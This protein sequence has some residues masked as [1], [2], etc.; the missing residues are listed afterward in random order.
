MPDKTPD[1]KLTTSD[2]RLSIAAGALKPAASEEL[3]RVG[4]RYGL[5]IPLT[6]T[7]STTPGTG[8]SADNMHA[9]V[10]ALQKR[11]NELTNENM[12]LKQQI[13]EISKPA[14]S[15][16]D[17]AR[18]LQHSLDT[19]QSRFSAMSNPISDFALKEFKLDSTVRIEVNKVGLIEYRFIQP[20]E[21]VR[22]QEISRIS[23]NAVP[24]PKQQTSGTMSR[25]SFTPLMGVEDID[26]VG[27][28]YRSIFNAH[29][30]YT[31]NDLLTTGTRVKNRVELSAML[32][33][34]RKALD[35]WI[36]QASLMTIR[37]VEGR[38][39]RVLFDIGITS[40]ELMAEETPATL[41]KKFNTRAQ[42]KGYSSIRPLTEER[43]AEWISTASQ[44]VGKKKIPVSPENETL[45]PS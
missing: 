34:D 3:L 35:N 37:D 4:D 13:E 5:F 20:G 40:L 16:D 15:P 22:E 18:A 38:D 41:I 9:I 23:I 25:P 6:D 30:I 44:F 43:A 31:I 24:L 11:I 7:S 2:T 28:K 10:E 39:A 36:S 42:T 33:M 27:D 19:I 1:I 14:H 12:S 29:Q 8:T 32:G 21:Q 26:G 45:S 17:F